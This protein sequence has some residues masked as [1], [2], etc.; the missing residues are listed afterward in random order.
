MK[1]RLYKDVWRNGRFLLDEQL[2]LPPHQ[3]MTPSLQEQ[4]VRLASEVGFKKTGELLASVTEDPVS[5]MSVWRRLQEVADGMFDDD[6]D[7]ACAGHDVVDLGEI[8]GS[9]V[10]GMVFQK[11]G[12]GLG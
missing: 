10:R 4:S 11:C 8:A 3:L 2:G 5:A 1:R 12:P 6:K 9:D 7:E